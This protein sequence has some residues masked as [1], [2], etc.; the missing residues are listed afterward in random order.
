MDEAAV[1]GSR[2]LEVELLSTSGKI[3]NGVGVTIITMG[4]GST[5]MDGCSIS[6]RRSIMITVIAEI[7]IFN[8]TI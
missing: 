2:A 7:M 3:T 8:K 6:H 1:I 5:N 4:V